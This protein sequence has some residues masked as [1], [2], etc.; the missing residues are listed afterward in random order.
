VLYDLEVRAY[1]LLRRER[2]RCPRILVLLVLPS[3]EERWL[4][5]T[6][7]ELILRRCVYWLSLR[8][9]A[10]TNVQKTIR[11]SISKQNVFSVEAVTSLMA[12]LRGGHQP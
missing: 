11:V 3:E 9:A 8:G 1:E 5:Q 6:T 7:E 10:P 12:A 4:S 2:P